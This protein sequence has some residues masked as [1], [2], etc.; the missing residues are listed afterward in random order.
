MTKPRGHDL[1]EIRKW[2]IAAARAA[3]D[4]K[5]E[6]TVVLDV[7]QVLAISDAFVI[8]SGGNDRQVRTIADEVR[9]VVAGVGGPVPRVVEGLDDATWVLIDFGDFVVHVFQED[10]R[11]YYDLERLWADS[12]RIDWEPTPSAAASGE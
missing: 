3:D 7:G 2:A 6:A 12:P 4:K 5:G 10:A 1:D 9:A 8:T 11:A